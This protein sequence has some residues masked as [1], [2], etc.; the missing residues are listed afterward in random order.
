MTAAPNRRWFR[1]S[2]R[3]LF[4]V[5]TLAGALIGWLVWELRYIHD[6][7]AMRGWILQHGG[8]V[9]KP[10]A[11]LNLPNPATRIPFWRELLGD[12]TAPVVI[13]PPG[14]L[15]ADLEQIKRTFPEAEVFIIPPAAH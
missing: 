1:F 5:M 10:A 13:L 6:R 7:T 11:I 15:T 12:E 3:T 4:V 14:L 8:G 9:P 2:L